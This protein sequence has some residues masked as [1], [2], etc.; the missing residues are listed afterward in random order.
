MTV[1][2]AAGGS[3]RG[4]PPLALAPLGKNGLGWAGRGMVARTFSKIPRGSQSCRNRRRPPQSAA[5]PAPP[6]CA[7]GVHAAAAGAQESRPRMPAAGRGPRGRRRPGV[8]PRWPRGA[9]EQAEDAGRGEGAPGTEVRSA[10]FSD[11]VVAQV[12]DFPLFLLLAFSPAAWLI[13]GCLRRRADRRAG[14]LELQPGLLCLRV[15]PGLGL[16]G[17]ERAAG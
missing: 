12:P 11:L 6:E 14:S 2:Q 10:C 7:P 8:S 17:K 15:L 4:F 1:C 16:V 13:R 9:G 5:S 3:R